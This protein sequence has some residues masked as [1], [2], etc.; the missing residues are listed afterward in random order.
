MD[1][2]ERYLARFPLIRFEEKSEN[3]QLL[4]RHGADVNASDKTHS[5]PLHLAPSKGCVESVK[6]LIQHGADVNA[7]NGRQSTPLHLAV[8]IHSA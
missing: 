2:T 6:L 3:V 7:K 5:T 4:V 8:T 1:R